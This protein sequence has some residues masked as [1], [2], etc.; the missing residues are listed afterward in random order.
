MDMAATSAGF[1]Q[2][3]RRQAGIA[4]VLALIAGYVDAYAL[5]N[6]NVFASFMSGNTTQSGLF[7]GQGHWL[8]AVLH[9]VPIP[10]FVVGV[11]LGT[12]LLE[13]NRRHGAR[14]LCSFVAACLAA[15]ILLAY[16]GPWAVWCSIVLLSVGMGVMNTAITHVGPQRVSLGFVTGD[17]NS[18]GQHL[19][20]A[21]RGSVLAHSAGAGDTHLRR[22]AVL[23]GIW[24]A[25]FLGAVL[26][27][28][29][30]VYVGKWTL[31]PPVVVL[32]VLAVWD[33]PRTEIE[34]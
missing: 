34:H 7:V 9:L 8:G 11:F 24:A 22:A 3:T 20:L 33:V 27:G 30:V 13:G 29:S 10:L 2:R 1:E 6:F 14:W 19:A 31:I 23:G 28:A 25:F 32:L 21:A 18:I 5:A 16:A 26:S 12:F 15:S 17:L 4:L